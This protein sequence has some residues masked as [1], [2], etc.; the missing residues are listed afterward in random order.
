MASLSSSA[1]LTCKRDRRAC[2][3]WGLR[4]G[5]YVKRLEPSRLRVRTL[6]RAGKPET[7]VLFHRREVVCGHEGPPRAPLQGG[8]A[9]ST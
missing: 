2:H 4:E 6:Q 8:E 3:V 1:F 5:T 9:D 7:L